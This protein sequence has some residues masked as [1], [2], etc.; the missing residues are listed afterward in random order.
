MYPNKTQFTPDRCTNC[1]CVNGTSICHRA[2]CPIL[3]CSEQYQFIDG[4]CPRC[5]SLEVSN[6]CSYN[7]ITY[8]NNTTWNLD[9]CRS[10]RCLNGDIRCSVLKCPETKCR[11]NEQLVQ[12]PKECCA[13]CVEKAGTC[14]VF[15]D[16]HFKTFDGK[17]FSFQG[18]CKYLLAK[19]CHDDT[20]TIRL[21][22]DGRNTSKSSWTKTV[23][24]KI[25]GIRVNLGQKMR[26]KVNGSRVTLPYSNYSISS[27][28]R[29]PEGVLLKTD[30]GVMVEWD[31]NN[32]LQVTVPSSY[33]RKMCG[34]CGNY[35][36]IVRDDLTGRD[37]NNYTDQKIWHFANSWKV[38]GTKACSRI[39]ESVMLPPTCS[40]RRYNPQCRPLRDLATHVFGNCNN[41]LNPVNYFD[42]CK[43]DACE[44][45]H[46]MCQC[47]S[48]AAYAHECARLGVKLPDW[49]SLTNCPYGVG[50]QKNTTISAIAASRHKQKLLQE[51]RRKHKQRQQQEQNQIQYDFSKYV[52]KDFLISKNLGTQP[53]LND[54]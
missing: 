20:F 38:G 12:N 49:R 9:S 21:T 2:T 52:P 14:T 51:R 42:A 45:P 6:E 44:C 3:D 53:P 16:P 23:T 25:K 13:K 10:C 36:G 39:Y 11:S 34:L 8:Q 37:N 43:M 15:G 19:D 26:V 33:K 30:L 47:D 7:G 18:S 28:E 24:I 50:W 54:D 32:F 35:N 22:N 40:K 17:F 1:T 27:I 48:F 5:I 4:C 29:L 41:H 46:G 31:G